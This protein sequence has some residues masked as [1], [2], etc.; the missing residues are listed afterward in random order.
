MLLSIAHLSLQ[1]DQAGGSLKKMKATFTTVLVP[2][3]QTSSV[4]SGVS[5]RENT[6][7][8]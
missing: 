6:R 2:F 3:K 7:S 8:F 5:L 1:W 4:W